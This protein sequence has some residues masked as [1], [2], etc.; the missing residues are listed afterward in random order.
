M[1]LVVFNMSNVFDWR[2]G[3]VNRNFFV[4]R[5]LLR[6]GRF[7]KVML[8]DFLAV[9]SVP[10]LFGLRR[11]A[12]YL[13]DCRQ[14]LRGKERLTA[15]HIVWEGQEVFG[16][17]KKV[18]VFSG[19]GLQ[20]R[21]RA[22]L[23]LL[24]LA[25]IRRGFNPADT[26][27]WSYNAFLPQAFEFPSPHRIFDAVDDWSLHASYKKE[28]ELLRKNYQ[29]IS[30]AARHIFTVSEGLVK[31]FPS[32]KAHWIPNGA[33]LSGFTQGL[34]LPD[35]LSALPHP[36]IGYVG[37]VQ[38][39]LD[40]RLLASVCGQHR[41]KTFVFIGPVW[42][43]V[44]SEVDA[45]KRSCPNALFLG[46]RSYDLVPSYLAGMDAAM[47]PHRLDA[48]ISTTNPMKMYDYLA[49]GKPVISTPGAGTEM[50]AS[51]MYIASDTEAF[52]Q[53]IQQA[54]QEDSEEKRQQ[55]RLAVQSH[56]WPARV[57]EML[58][59]LESPAIVTAS[60]TMKAYAKAN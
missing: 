22:D 21:S 6:S 25:L 44:Q 39:R 27:L 49:A 16:L 23:R 24:K 13:R 7:E 18:S 52:S 17:E 30:G 2:R 8:V 55:R 3:I 60:A 51:H 20:R 54:I 56:A 58:S 11:T 48:F 4:V 50:F 28:A 38:E 53:A 26:V 35:D 1:N 45:L 42:K 41:D 5:E 37:T 32:E 40:F 46:R 31:A 10:R 33:D 59:Y 34:S 43:G 29:Q 19:L 15:R 57:Q 14:P 47:I 12:R 9:R 36:L